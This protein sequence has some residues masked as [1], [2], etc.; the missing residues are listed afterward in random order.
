MKEEFAQ[1]D[2]EVLKMEKKN[3]GK[4]KIDFGE[5]TNSPSKPTK[6][7]LEHYTKKEKKPRHNPPKQQISK[8]KPPKILKFKEKEESIEDL[9]K[10]IERKRQ[11]LETK[12][13]EEELKRQREIQMQEE[14]QLQKEIFELQRDFPKEMELQQS[15]ITKA[16]P[17]P[18]VEFELQS[19]Q[20][21]QN[22]KL[23]SFD[24]SFYKIC[25]L[26]QKKVRHSKV[27]G[28]GF[29]LKQKFKCKN[30]LCLWEKE[31]VLKV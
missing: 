24:T 3:I 25:P 31:I 5:L 14:I 9:E 18:A 20:D 30:K 6:K 12:K 4:V 8:E 10:E 29:I 16:L 15:E 26:C 21:S 2:R 11:L 1:K 23:V 28:D 27:E 7:A 17:E 22:V 19:A 13:Q